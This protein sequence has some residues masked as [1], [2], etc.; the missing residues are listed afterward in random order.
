MRALFGGAS[1]AG[2]AGIAGGDV[3]EGGGDRLPDPKPRGES[4]ACEVDVRGSGAVMVGQVHVRWVA[5]EQHADRLGGPLGYLLQR[6]A[7]Q[8]QQ[9]FELPGGPPLNSVGC[10][11]A[12]PRRQGMRR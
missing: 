8:R 10:R 2:E 4:V 11:T 6:F 5:L 1:A 7:H 9:W 3:C 12:G